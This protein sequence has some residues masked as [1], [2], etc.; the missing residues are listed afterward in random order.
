MKKY[1]GTDLT[2]YCAYSKLQAFIE[3]RRAKPGSFEEFEVALGKQMRAL[4]NEVK[5]E[6]LARYD[7]DA[8]TIVVGGVTMTKCL[9]KEKKWYLTSSGPVEVARDVL[10]FD[11]Q[12]QAAI[13][14][15]RLGRATKRL[16]T[17]S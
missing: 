15:R 12:T 17:A 4:E 6:Q 3:K 11:F 7:I 1:H 10:A 14:P 8:K 13:A 9:N 16:E 2:Q 5:A